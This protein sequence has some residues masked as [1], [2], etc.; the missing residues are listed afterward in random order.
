M[1]RQIFFA[2]LVVSI[3]TFS[4]WAI[5]KW[6]NAFLPWQTNTEALLFVSIS[7]GVLAALTGL[8]NTIDLI[9]YL[10]PSQCS[11][12]LTDEMH[13]G[14]YTRDT[15]VSSAH[16]YIRPKCSNIDPTNEREIRHALVATREDLFDIVDNFLN[17][18]DCAR[19]LLILADSGTGKTSFMLAYYAYNAR[20]P[21]NKRHNIV[22][23]PLGARNSDE[24]IEQIS[25]KCNNH[26][27]LDA[28]DE[29]VAAI[30]DHSKRILDL[31]QK[32]ASFRKV[33]LTCR[34][35]F[36]PKDDEIPVET[37]IL[38]HGPR[39]A[40]ERGVYEFW[41]L[42]LSPFDDDDVNSYLRKRYPIWK[43]SSR[44][45]A[46]SIAIAIPLLSVRP[47]LLAH[48]PDIVA[49]NL[50]IEHSYD[51]YEVMIEA[52][53]RRESSWTNKI[54][55]R[56]FSERLAVDL[57]L[58]RRHRGEEII[59]S[60]ELPLLAEKWGLELP[61]WQL[62]GRSLLNRDA[63][64]NF[65][66]AHRSIMEYLFVY[67]VL[68]SFDEC[69]ESNHTIHFTD[70]MKRFFC[71]LVFSTEYKPMLQSIRVLFDDIVLY[72]INNGG[73]PV[74][75]YQNASIRIETGRLLSQFVR[76]FHFT[77]INEHDIA[78]LK[79]VSSATIY[80]DR[81]KGDRVRYNYMP[82][83]IDKLRTCCHDYLQQ[84][85]KEYAKHHGNDNRIYSERDTAVL[86]LNTLHMLKCEHY[87]SLIACMRSESLCNI[88]QLR[89]VPI[90]PDFNECIIERMS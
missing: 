78:M 81:A 74:L 79:M 22:L 87:Q 18:D 21:K 8:K 25:D 58:K 2:L 26:I 64:G 5:N 82:N 77:L 67:R 38:R 56:K 53:L 50:Q 30:H 36:F 9:G 49:S 89:L 20:K 69:F 6:V 80:G 66:F 59:S 45:K 29:D 60:E 73:A 71:E 62:T 85:N 4:L 23:V 84:V 10:R 13:F 33:I 63:C 15:I 47:M 88:Y 1:K 51:L 57:Y 86:V 61:R 70:Q 43:Y 90:P 3:S 28:L 40:G 12:P 34:T 14:P 72:A 44:R 48:I 46:R 27:F 7:I 35:Q 68:N 17:S 76:S 24:L 16:H 75:Y 55:L 83:A 52:W 54:A 42:Y 39:K 37:G 32:C 11:D 19:H 41:K 65:K 31:M